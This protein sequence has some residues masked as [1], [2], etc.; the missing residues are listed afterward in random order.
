MPTFGGVAEQPQEPRE[1]ATHANKYRLEAIV[2]SYR[3]ALLLVSGL[4]VAG[5]CVLVGIV[6]FNHTK[7]RLGTDVFVAFAT[8]AVGLLIT[9]AVEDKPS[10]ERPLKRAAVMAS[11]TV[12]P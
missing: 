8:V 7:T 2:M 12:P 9:V 1:V 5:A 11:R 6:L 10:H 4:L 3:R